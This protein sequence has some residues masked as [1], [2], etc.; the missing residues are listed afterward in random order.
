VQEDSKVQVVK[1]P[2]SGGTVTSTKEQQKQMRERCI[3]AYFKGPDNE[4]QPSLQKLRLSD[5]KVYKAASSVAS[6]PGLLPSGMSGAIDPTRASLVE[7]SADMV[8]RHLLPSCWCNVDAFVVP[9]EPPVAIQLG[10]KLPA[11]KGCLQAGLI[12]AVSYTPDAPGVAA[13]NVA[14]FVW[15]VLQQLLLCPIC[16]Q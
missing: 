14:G 7:P 4:L 6:Q 8:R 16:S 1:V 13:S 10:L 11:S 9:R 15:C 5:I 12:L 2:K 3:V